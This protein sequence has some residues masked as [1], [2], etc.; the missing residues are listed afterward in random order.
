MIGG[1]GAKVFICII[2][3]LR[4]TFNI[5]MITTPILKMKN[6]K[7]REAKQVTWDHTAT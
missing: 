4:V 5:G 6:L 1:H 3:I 2:L 7:L